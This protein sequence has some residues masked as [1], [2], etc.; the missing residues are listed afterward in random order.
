MLNNYINM[1]RH[2]AGAFADHVGDRLTHKIDRIVLDVTSESE[3]VF[4]LY[5][6]CCSHIKLRVA[7]KS[8]ALQHRGTFL[9]DVVNV[10]IQVEFQVAAR[11]GVW[12]EVLSRSWINCADI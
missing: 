10:V 8:G 4:S 7:A 6:F 2:Y 3:K 12:L 9:D 11:S 5:Q 1:V